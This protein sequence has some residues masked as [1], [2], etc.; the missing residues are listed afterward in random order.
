M[1]I[2]SKLFG[3]VGVATLGVA[4]ASG[5]AT[6]SAPVDQD[7]ITASV[8]ISCLQPM[9]VS[10][11]GSD[12]TF[13]AIT[14]SYNVHDTSTGTGAIQVTVDMGCYFGPWQVS[15]QTTNFLQQGGFGWFSASHLSL[16]DANVDTYAL[17]AGDFLGTLEPD[18]SNAYFSGPYDKD[19]ILETS[20]NWIWW[21][22]WQQAPD[23]PAPFVTVA[24]YT[25][26][27]TN[28]PTAIA[29]GTYQATLTVSL[30]TD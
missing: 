25:G 4:L 13:A 2:K 21:F 28:L 1:S 20:E 17:S 12:A 19:T 26:K 18:A 6:A 8:D 22:G 7:S 30:T 3:L 11:D 15:A 10:L 24:S 29:T 5:L 9:T 27:L 14:D 23:S 16:V